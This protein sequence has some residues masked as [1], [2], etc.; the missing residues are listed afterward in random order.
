MLRFYK[1]YL[2]SEKENG[3]YYNE[4]YE[5]GMD[6]EADAFGVFRY[7][8][9]EVEFDMELD[10]ETGK[11]RILAVQGVKLERPVKA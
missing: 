11:T 1:A 3:A 4:E 6:E 8:L 2:H 5:L 10:T 9:H 7:S